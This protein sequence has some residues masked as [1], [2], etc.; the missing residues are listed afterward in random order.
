MTTLY[1]VANTIREIENQPKRDISASMRIVH[2][3]VY[4][5]ASPMVGDKPTMGYILKSFLGL[6]I[7]LIEV[8]AEDSRIPEAINA[9]LTIAGNR[10]RALSAREL[11][12]ALLRAADCHSTMYDNIV[13][14]H[15]AE[16]FK[17]M[18]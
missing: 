16:D 7:A 12:R 17:V 8:L 15:Y 2:S 3:V 18:S 6:P 10:G 4:T 11:V 14:V 5:A 13:R 1:E 9:R